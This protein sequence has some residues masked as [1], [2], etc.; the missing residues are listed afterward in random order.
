M[1]SAFSA[2]ACG[3]CSGK[4]STW[5]VPRAAP[6]A[7]TSAADA[8]FVSRRFLTLEDDIAT[9]TAVAVTAGRIVALG[10]K[11]ELLASS[12]KGA[13]TVVTDLGDACVVPG[14]IE[15]HAHPVMYGAN[16]EQVDVTSDVTDTMVAVLAA[17]KAAVDS[18]PEGSWITANGYDQGNMATPADQRPLLAADLDTVAPNHYVTVVSNSGHITYV[19][20][21]VLKKA[22]ISAEGDPARGGSGGNGV[23]V[24]DA[25]GNPTGELQGSASTPVNRLIPKPTADDTARHMRLAAVRFQSKGLTTVYD[26]ATNPQSLTCYQDVVAG[27]MQDFPLR[28]RMYPIAAV[29][30]P[31]KSMAAA[32]PSP[33]FGDDRLTMGG[34]KSWSDGSLQGYTGFL[35]EPYFQGAPCPCHVGFA[36]IGQP[37]LEQLCEDVV[38]GGYQMSIH[39]NGDKAID[40]TIDAYAHALKANDKIGSDHRLVIQHCQTPREEQLVRMGKLGITASFFANHVW[41]YGDAH[42]D[43][44]LGE[45]RANRISP[46]QSANAAGVKWGLHSDAPIT[47]CD[48]LKTMWTVVTRQTRTGKTLG[49]D[50]CVTPEQALRAYTIDNAYLGFEENEKGSLA[51]GKLADFAVLSADPLEACAEDP[52]LLLGIDIIGTVLG[53]VMVMNK[54]DSPSL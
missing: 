28:I 47:E 18:L 22:E 29:F 25:D 21:L 42:R 41:Y 49:A 11:D 31:G 39:A 16:F 5:G 19:N 43:I 50:Q 12:W 13:S 37:D 10:E 54:A 14:F 3:P 17:I 23:V 53:G 46:L 51:V 34:M 36:Y 45:E 9:C 52:E 24:C 4:V 35:S 32:S 30:A 38:G 33:G 26:M 6:A 48:P 8:I 20:T 2:D 40:N 27:P 7:A 1:A 44:F 15:S